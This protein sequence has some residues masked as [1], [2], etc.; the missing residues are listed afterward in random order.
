M[1]IKSAKTLYKNLH[2]WYNWNKYHNI[3]K[4]HK[5]EVFTMFSLTGQIEQLSIL[6]KI[7][8][9]TAACSNNPQRFV[10][11]LKNNFELSL[12]IPPR[13]YHNYYSSATN[14]RD[15]RL[16]SI[17]SALLLGSY[18]HLQNSTLVLLLTFSPELR[19]FCKL[20]GGR[21]PDESVFSKFKVQFDKDLLEFF[22]NISMRVVGL[23]AEYDKTLPDNSPLKGLC[24]K[25]IY[26]TSGAKP[27]VRENNPQFT[28]SEIKRQKAYQKV[29]PN[30][31]FNPYL[32]AYANLPKFARA[33][34]DIRLDYAN[35][36]F[37]YFYK[38]GIVSNGFGA[39]L[40]I[41]FLDDQFYKSLP[42]SF[43]TPEEQKYAYDNASL[44]PALSSFLHRF[45]RNPFNTFLADSEFDSYANY[46][47]LRANGFEK[48]L[49]PINDRNS[50][51]ADNITFP[52]DAQFTP[53][54]PKI[55]APFIPD[56]IVKGKKRSMRLKFV[57][58]KSLKV[59]GRWTCECKTKCRKTNS[60][61]TTYVYPNGD[62]RL[63]PGVVRGSDEWRD[64]Y[65][66]RTVIERSLSS[67]K[68]NPLVAAPNTYNL[69][70]IR[71]NILLAAATK[72]ITVI[73]AFAIGQPDLMLNLRELTHA[74]AKSYVA[75]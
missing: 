32:A 73:L 28:A 56:G 55:K 70:A 47:F 64:T 43:Q 58:P 50:K 13:F 23:F 18:F 72:L 59:K 31:G 41:H 48:I 35:G 15:Y 22:N 49:I 37:A 9:V 10:E 36:H 40:H 29:C 39:P 30:K 5:K 27:K 66:T 68:S 65:K 34:P 33:N 26:D 20:P 4:T 8:E 61:V 25:A 44:Q 1:L 3:S 42:G 75:A 7:T 63:F 51:Q 14:D 24:K 6:E 17:L 2:L 12:F 54:C 38:Y 19:D 45:K 11:F 69:A 46:D 52:L 71:S 74:F 57:C 67:L 16:E 60:T 53:T 21:V 62:L